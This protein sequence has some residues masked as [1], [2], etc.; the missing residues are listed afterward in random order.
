MPYVDLFGD[1]VVVYWFGY[2]DDFLPPDGISIMDE[3]ILNGKCC[4]KS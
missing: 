3:N 2:L 4:K 1:G